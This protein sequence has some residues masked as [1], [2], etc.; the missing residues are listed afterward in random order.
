MTIEIQIPPETE[1]RLRAIAAAEGKEP[2]A[3]ALEALQDRL[4]VPNGPSTPPTPDARA[5]AW[6][7]FIA[8][9]HDWTR[10]L[11]SGHVANDSRESVYEDRGE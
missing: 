8:G 11:P 3:V 2:A 1:A 5:A 7:R 4:G 9:M 10:R 6:D